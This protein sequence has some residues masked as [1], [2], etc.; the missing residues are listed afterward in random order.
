MAQTK[1]RVKIGN[2]EIEMEGE[3][4]YIEGKFAE[5]FKKLVEEKPTILQTNVPTTSSVPEQVQQ[6]IEHKTDL[7]GIFEIKTNG[8]PHLTVPNA[9]KKLSIT[10][11]V[12][13]L[14]YAY[15]P[16][17]VTLNEMKIIINDNYQSVGIPTLSSVISRP[18]RNRISKEGI[19]GKYAYGLS[20]S[21]RDYVKEILQKLRNS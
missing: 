5:V 6:P 10:E 20:Q 3:Q 11:V 14:L 19:R 9:A 13:L 4:T 15:E 12:V 1:F 16:R 2:A 8:E 21:G 17:K 18:L 7:D